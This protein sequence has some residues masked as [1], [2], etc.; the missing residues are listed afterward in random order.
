MVHGI[1]LG[2]VKI[3]LSLVILLLIIDPTFIPHSK[4]ALNS[5]CKGIKTG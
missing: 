5:W 1:G 3:M 4:I 2:L